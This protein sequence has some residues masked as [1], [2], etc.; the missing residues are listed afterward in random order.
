MRS[1]RSQLS[2][3]IM[4]IVLVMVALVSFLA[5]IAV[6]RQFEEYI[7][8]QEQQQREKIIDDLENLYNGM[9]RRWNADYLHAIGM[10]L[11]YDGYVL[12]VYDAFGASVWDAESHDMALCREIM[13]DITE[14]MRQRNNNGGFT[15]YTYELKQG[16]QRIGT[17]AIKVY[18]PY[19]LRENEYHFI[20]TLNAL[21]LII[22]VVSCIVSV[23]T[24]TVLAH[25]IARPITKTAEIARR[26]SGGN[27]SIR[28]EGATKTQE[29]S[30]LIESINN[31]AG[32]LDRQEQHRKQLTADIAHELRTPLAA[33]RSHLEAMADGLWEATPE[34][35]VSCV[36]EV[37]RLSSL[38]V[39]LD[40]LAK[41]EQ[42]NVKLNKAPVDLLEIAS[43][44]LANFEKEAD[45]K[46]LSITLDGTATCLNAD[47]DRMIQ[48][49][50]NLVS[51]AIKYTPEGG[52]IRIEVKDDSENGFV[53]VEDSGI[54]IA[55]KD[56]PY[57]FERFYRTDQSR[58]RKTGGAGI[59]LTIV[60]SIV[61][62]H[63]GKITAESTEGSGSRFTVC[64]PQKSRI[65]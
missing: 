39:D 5:N 7:V 10:Y 30:M 32:A 8:S 38:I 47:R 42:D 15:N 33:L 16:E 65:L 29:L 34:R 56:L 9:T 28:F 45:N 3:Y 48:V 55:S 1:L 61:E 46:K 41:L 11:L 6:N 44:V 40:R 25:R 13:S 19:F 35:L 22:G 59:G 27:Y 37:K 52:Q 63:G 12:S 24:G 54:G 53:V 64:L 2:L 20:N 50:T 4:T 18:G 62:A 23:I 14:R 31:M 58:N 49:V 60:K 17:A 21:F 26:I 36:E 51:N 43:A 57:I